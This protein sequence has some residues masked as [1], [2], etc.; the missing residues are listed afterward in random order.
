[1]QFKCPVKDSME[2]VKKEDG[3]TGKCHANNLPSPRCVASS[4]HDGVNLPITAR[5]EPED[6][7]HNSGTEFLE[8]HGA[9]PTF[10]L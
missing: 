8:I 9:N 7:N 6:R 3:E 5:A 4:W 10:A 2:V 1:M